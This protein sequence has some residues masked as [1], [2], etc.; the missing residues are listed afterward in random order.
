MVWIYLVFTFCF[1]WRLTTRLRD[2]IEGGGGPQSIATC[3][4][5]SIP[6]AWCAGYTSVVTATWGVLQSFALLSDLEPS[7]KVVSWCTLAMLGAIV[8][9]GG[10]ETR[11][12]VP[13]VSTQRCSV[14]LGCLA[15][16]IWLASV[17]MTFG[18]A[19]END[20]S[21]TAPQFFGNDLF[22]HTTL[23]R[24]FSFGYNFPTEYPFLQGQGIRYHF[25]FYFGGGVLEALGAPLSVALNLP[26]AFGLGSFLSLIAFMAWRLS[27]SLLGAALAPLLCLFRS[28]LSWIDWLRTVVRTFRWDAPEAPMPFRFGTTPYEDWGIFSLIVHLNQ[29]HL[30]YGFAWMLLALS[31]C[32]FTTPIRRPVGWA[33]A[34]TYAIFGCLVGCG[35]YWNG[36]AFLSTMMALSPL[37]FLR[38]YRAKALLILIPAACSSV[39]I[40]SLVTYGALLATPFQ[41]FF[42]FGFLSVSQAPLDVLAYF[43]WIFG[44]LPFVAYSAGRRYGSLGLYLFVAG[45]LPIGAV[46]FAQITAFA[47]QGHKLVN[48]GV[49]LWSIV[50]AG[51]VASMLVAA[52]RG[53]RLS[54][55]CI[56]VLLVLTGIADLGALVHL[57]GKKQSF[58]TDDPAIRW[59]AAH[60]ARDAVFLSALRGGH[61][62]YMGGRRA[63]LGPRNYVSEAGY[64]YDERVAWLREVASREPAEQVRA[65]R[66]KGIAYLATERCPNHSDGSHDSCPS[67][68]E[69]DTLSGNPLLLLVYDSQ[70]FVVREVPRD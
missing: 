42:R 40:V 10:R 60:T 28:S 18:I 8:V 66:E 65:L 58:A 67:V 24:S 16:A 44:V 6:L 51:L 14:T 69:V 15:S 21:V 52:R 19:T 9:R 1:G 30:M 55:Q 45:L 49:V 7:L 64:S 36:A 68:P 38:R 13:P 35:A 5:F 56:L 47:P 29:R 32:I 50:S 26:A 48:A 11:V 34:R 27:G 62:A 41:P 17:G 46:F 4:L 23:I 70:D 59:V 39:C 53:I 25:L 31:V 57:V 20:G 61:P 37:V 12:A 33:A 3:I 43:I 22:S 63:F 54:G 2:A